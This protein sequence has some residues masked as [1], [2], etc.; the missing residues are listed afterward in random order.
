[1][2]TLISWKST[3]YQLKDRDPV[4]LSA[5]RSVGL[6]K[7]TILIGR[8]E[9]DTRSSEPNPPLSFEECH[10]NGPAFS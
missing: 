4:R 6:R 9:F 5:S 2:V 10:W 7:C 8:T 1:M 3:V